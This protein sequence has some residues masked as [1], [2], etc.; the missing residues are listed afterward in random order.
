MVAPETGRTET[1]DT[2]AKYEKPVLVRVGSFE[3]ITQAG[4]PGVNFDVVFPAGT[5]AQEF[6]FS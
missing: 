2:K 4:G 5:P 1:M 3:E 6:T